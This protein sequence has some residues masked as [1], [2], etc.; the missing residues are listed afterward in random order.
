MEILPASTVWPRC[1]KVLRKARADIARVLS[2]SPDTI[3]FTSGGSEADSLAIQG[4]ALR[5]MHHGKHLI[6]TAIEHHAVF[7]YHGILRAT[8]RL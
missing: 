7:A 2:V 6:T 5:N 1:N 4:Y 8:F 3:I